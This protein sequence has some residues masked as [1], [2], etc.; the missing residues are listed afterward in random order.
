M[1]A[2]TRND[3]GHWFEAQPL[4]FKTAV[5]Y[6]I[7]TRA[8]FDANGDGSGDFRGLTEKLDYLQWLGV[9]CIWL[10]PLVA[11]INKAR[12]ENPALQHLS[13]IAFLDT[14]NDALIAYAKRS[15]DNTVITAVNLDPH[16]TQEGS[17]TIPA[18]L[19]LP[20][21][22]GVTDLL[23]GERFDWR[24]GPNFV[25]L[26]PWTRQAHILRVDGA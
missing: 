25:R 11:K 1:A 23:S 6:E 9:D 19:G 22:F 26:D 4:W 14:E 13:N 21:A 12:R 20:P 17:I 16:H 7:H 3:P 24:I 18:H 2:G 15:G 8:F 10:L 5:F